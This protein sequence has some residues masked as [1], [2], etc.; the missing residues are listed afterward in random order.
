MVQAVEAMAHHAM[1]LRVCGA[2]GQVHMPVAPPL[3]RLDARRYCLSC[4]ITRRD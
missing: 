1:P 3:P 2:E 4:Y